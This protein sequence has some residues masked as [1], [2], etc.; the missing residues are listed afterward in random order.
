ME[1]P[2]E[3]AWRV[4]TKA[5]EGVRVSYDLKALADRADAAIGEGTM[6][7]DESMDAFEAALVARVRRK[8]LITILLAVGAPVGVFLFMIA[9]NFRPQLER[10]MAEKWEVTDDERAEILKVLDAARIKAEAREAAWTAALPSLD[11]IVEREDLGPCP[12]R[13]RP[14][15]HQSYLPKG[16][17]S[18]AFNLA[19]F[20]RGEDPTGSGVLSS[21]EWTTARIF[22]ALEEDHF[23]PDPGAELLARARDAGDLDGDDRYA[24]IFRQIDRKDAW[25]NQDD[26]FEPGFIVGRAWVWDHIDAEV[27]C[28]TTVAAT[29]SD[30][31]EVQTVTYGYDVLD[32]AGGVQIFGQLKTDLENNVYQAIAEGMQWRAGPIAG[33]ALSQEQPALELSPF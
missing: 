3:G 28:A 6:E 8:R 9:S 13:L 33:G 18:P 12:T 10:A 23:E 31:L 17:R 27:V 14:P 16:Q 24:V 20:G 19:W 21:V 25:K 11:S 22:E 7:P 4:Y 29:N 2:E 5:A 30:T 26:T 1:V 32:Q 15:Q